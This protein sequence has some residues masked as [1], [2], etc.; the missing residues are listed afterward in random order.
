MH[1]KK[2]NIFSSF[3]LLIFKLSW[4]KYSLQ[5]GPPPVIVSGIY[6]HAHV[7]AAGSKYILQI[8]DGLAD[9]F[10]NCQ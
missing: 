9:F 10:F 8:Y 1:R 4:F 5:D 6:S 7:T 3:K 2:C